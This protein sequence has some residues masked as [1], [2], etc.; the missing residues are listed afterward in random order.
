MSKSKNREI[1]KFRNA[2][3]KCNFNGLRN[4]ISE[5]KKYPRSSWSFSIFRIKAI[6][7]WKQYQNESNKDDSLIDYENDMNDRSTNYESHKND[8]AINYEIS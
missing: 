1:S 7:E 5:A 6:S 8:R 4:S 2:T 3:C